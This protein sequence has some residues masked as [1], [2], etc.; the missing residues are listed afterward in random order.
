MKCTRCQQDNP[1]H[2]KFC[3]EC[4]TPLTVITGQSSADQQTDI[5]R[6]R[7]ELSEA[8]AQQTA[9]G[10][11][12]RVIS[13]S[14]ADLQPV[15]D[16]VVKSA[17][18]FC[19]AYDAVLFRLDGGALRLAAHHGPLPAPF[20]LLVPMVRGTVGGRSVLERLPIH[21]ADVQ[22][23][24]GE[25]PES[26]AFAREVGPR[27]ILAV[28]LLREGAAIGTLQLRRLEPDPFTD[29]QISLLQT[30]A[31]QAVS[32]HRECASVHGAQVEQ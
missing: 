31:D 17:V 27:N 9:T 25:F 13:S 4:G 16:T 7:R 32:R 2:A 19:G 23:E 29:K 28:P 15:L 5:G 24:A 18:R 30:F 22:A 6:L 3:I 20:G 11:I 1:S 21:V 8:H 12:L 14:P 10:D 26:S